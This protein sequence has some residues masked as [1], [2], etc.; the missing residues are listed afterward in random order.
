LLGAWAGRRSAEAV[1]EDLER[2]LADRVILD[3]EGVDEDS[4]EEEVLREQLARLHARF[5]TQPVE[6]GSREVDLLLELWQAAWKA[7]DTESAWCEVIAALIR[8]PAMG[9]Y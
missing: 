9:I 7:G 4:P 6:T 3:L 8:H 1:I 5:L 2:D